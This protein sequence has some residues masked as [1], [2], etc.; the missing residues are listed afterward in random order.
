VLGAGFGASSEWQNLSIQISES[1]RAGKM[2]A[3]LEVTIGGRA[4]KQR[5]LMQRDI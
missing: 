4:L 3:I 5:E 1:V 2:E